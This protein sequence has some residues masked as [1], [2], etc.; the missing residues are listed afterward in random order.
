MTIHWRNSQKPARFF[1]LD[2]RSF[3]A[4]FFFLVHARLW[5]FGLAIVVIIL[6]WI[7]E[8]RGL[9]F[10]ASLRALRSWLLGT[11]RP[12]NAGRSKRF[13]IDYG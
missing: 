8:Q 11:K 3:A 9:T 7:L 10:H 5:T 2:A 1:V 12:A 6:F 13:W 4:V